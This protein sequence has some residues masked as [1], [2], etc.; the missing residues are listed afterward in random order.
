MRP[1]G[2][3]RTRPPVTMRD[4]HGTRSSGAR[5]L[6]DGYYGVGNVGDEAILACVLTQVRACF[7]DPSVVVSSENPRHTAENHDVDSV[8][9]RFRILGSKLEWV[10]ALRECDVLII[11]GGGLFSLNSYTTYC[12]KVLLARLFGTEVHI[13]SM[14]GA[15]P[16]TG[17][18]QTRQLSSLLACSDSIS[19]RDQATKAAFERAN[20]N[21]DVEKLSDIVYSADHPALERTATREDRLLV[22]VR[23]PKSRGFDRSSLCDAIEALYERHEPDILFLPFNQN[24]NP[25]DGHVAEEIV[26]S[27]DC[28]ADVYSGTPTWEEATDLIARSETVVAMRL[29]SIILSA[30]TRSKFVGISYEGKCDA[31]LRALGIEEPIRSD[32][33]E[34]ADLESELNAMWTRESFPSDVSARAEALERSARDVVPYLRETGPN[35]PGVGA[36]GRLA[37]LAIAGLAADLVTMTIIGF[38]E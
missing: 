31:Q 3:E 33:L 36:V 25:P 8:V 1:R 37:V 11:G 9:R 13:A 12:L 16:A 22:C 15:E 30:R 29:H 23:E 7:D 2:D 17:P 28:P 32:E 6:I 27:L 14:G 26:A 35:P 10:S 20:P 34:S 18:L 21:V 24:C 38:D 19:V 4:T 5:I